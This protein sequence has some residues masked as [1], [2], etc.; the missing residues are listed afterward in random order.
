MKGGLEGYERAGV[1]ARQE[2]WGPAVQDIPRRCKMKQGLAIPNRRWWHSDRARGRWAERMRGGTAAG[3]ARRGVWGEA[4]HGGRGRGE[5]NLGGCRGKNFDKSVGTGCRLL[6][7]TCMPIAADHVCAV[8]SWPHTCRLVPRLVPTSSALAP[9]GATASNF[10]S[11]RSPASL[12]G[13]LTYSCPFSSRSCTSTSGTHLWLPRLPPQSSPSYSPPAFD[14]ISP[15]IPLAAFYSTTSPSVCR[16]PSG[17]GPN[18][19][20]C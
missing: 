11:P 16:L 1:E 13:T 10:I 4:C 3:S 7:I 17:Y 6:L 5:R 20:N 2:I 8:W 19:T 9:N 12:P 18:Q 15:R 14:S